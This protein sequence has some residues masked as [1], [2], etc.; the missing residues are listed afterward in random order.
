MQNS[1]RTYQDCFGK[2]SLRTATQMN[3]L[4]IPGLRNRPPKEISTDLASIIQAR[5][6]RKIIEI[7]T[8]MRLCKV[9][10]IQSWLAALS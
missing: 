2:A 4:S 10:T 7:V 3:S 1:G 8:G 5:M 6:R 9:A